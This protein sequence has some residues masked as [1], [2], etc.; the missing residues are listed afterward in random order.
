[1]N[2]VRVDAVVLA[3]GLSKRMG[4]S[5]KL[6]QDIAGVS[7]IGRVVDAALGS[8]VSEVVV[9]TGHQAGAIESAL[10]AREVGLVHN[11]GFERGMGSSIAAGISALS[12]DVDA[13]L[14]CLGDMPHILSRQLDRLIQAFD[15]ARGRSICVLVHAGERGHPVLFGAEHFAE[16]R[17]L[18]GDSGARRILEANGGAVCSIVATDAGVTRDVDTPDELAALANAPPENA[19]RPR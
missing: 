16:L 17:R 5:N 3:A 18:D 15:P 13:A 6:V 11:T 19:A 2:P 9:V 12:G 10:G 7:M 8:D 14:I 4:S 1:M